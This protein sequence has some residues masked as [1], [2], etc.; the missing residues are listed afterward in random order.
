MLV[1]GD[2]AALV[3][4]VAAVAAAQRQRAV[5]AAV[6]V[7][8]CDPGYGWL[9]ASSDVPPP[10]PASLIGPARWVRHDVAPWRD[11]VLKRHWIARGSCPMLIASV[12]AVSPRRV[13]MSPHFLRW[14]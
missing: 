6:Q 4:A 14:L 7:T 5:S 1:P 11:A 2:P 12:I 3:E 13:L 9:A 8:F 10:P